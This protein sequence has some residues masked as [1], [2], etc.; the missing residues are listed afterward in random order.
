[1]S[2]I[3]PTLQQLKSQGRKELIPYVN[4]GDPYPDATVDIMIE[5]AS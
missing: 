3:T 1:M 4:A 5:L 2:R